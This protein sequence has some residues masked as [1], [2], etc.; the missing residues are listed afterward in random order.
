MPAAIDAEIQDRSG[1]GVDDTR[2]ESSPS[3]S[4]GV[5]TAVDLRELPTGTTLNIETAHSIYRILVLDGA[6]GRVL[7]QG[8]RLFLEPTR[9]RIEGSMRGGSAPWIGSICVGF[10]FDFSVSEDR[11]RTSPVVAINLH[12]PTR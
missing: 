6:T 4:R 1:T 8:G 3:V 7:L 10:G 5:V 12:L 2:P 9:A 11:A